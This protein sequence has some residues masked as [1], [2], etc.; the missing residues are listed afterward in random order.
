MREKL[1]TLSSDNGEV[2]GNATRSGKTQKFNI[3]CGKRAPEKKSFQQ[4]RIS[5]YHF[6]MQHIRAATKFLDLALEHGRKSTRS[7]PESLFVC[8]LKTDQPP[9]LLKHERAE[10]GRPNRLKDRER[11]ELVIKT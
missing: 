3:L 10:G 4:A 9:F 6:C 5:T 7:S 11:H 8:F 2:D 1:G